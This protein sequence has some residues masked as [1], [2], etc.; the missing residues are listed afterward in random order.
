MKEIS[1]KP[2]EMQWE[3]ARGDPPGARISILRKDESGTIR[4][5][6][7]QVG[8]NF[9]T[10][11]HTNTIGEEQFVLEGEIQTGGRSYVEG[12]Y[13]FIPKGASHEPWSSAR[14]AVLLV[15]WE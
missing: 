11:G 1:V 10:G 15:R 3:E 6:L 2:G 9:R 5:M 7:I 8:R 13:R 14:G 12:S 4:T